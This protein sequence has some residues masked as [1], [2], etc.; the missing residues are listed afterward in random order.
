[1]VNN[2]IKIEDIDFSSLEIRLEELCS[3]YPEAYNL[4]IQDKEVG[5]LKVRGGIFTVEYDLTSQIIFTIRVDGDGCFCDYERDF[6]LRKGIKEVI[7][8]HHNWINNY[9]EAED[10]S[11]I[12]YSIRRN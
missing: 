10:L 4:F 9:K 5:Y 7:L 8:F 6:F 1:M 3:D 12:K 11:Q 2:E